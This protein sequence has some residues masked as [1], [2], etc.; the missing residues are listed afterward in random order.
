M[1]ALV[2]TNILIDYLNGIE[3]ARQ[4]MSL[5]D[6][7]AISMVTWMEV[8]VGAREPHREATEAFLARFVLVEIDRPVAEKTV[9][10]RRQHRL[11]LPDAIVWAS[12]QVQDRILVSRDS[13]DMPTG[14]PGI[15]IPYQL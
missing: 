4:E 2:D 13:K 7:I 8:M 9:A 10:L 3:A 11:K 5:Y 1:K 14:H 15:R 12:A 6:D